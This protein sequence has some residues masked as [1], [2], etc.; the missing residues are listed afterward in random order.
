MKIDKVFAYEQLDSRG[1]PTIGIIMYSKNIFAKTLIPSG[2][3]TGSKEAFELRDNE[4]SYFGKGVNKAINN[5]NNI[6]SNKIIGLSIFEQRK[7]DNLMIELDGT[8]NKSNLGANAILAVSTCLTKL[9]AKALEIPL[10]EYISI[11]LFKNKEVVKHIPTPMINIINGG[12]HSNN[13]LT[14]QEFMIVPSKNSFSNQLK[15]CC[16]IFHLLGKKLEEKKYSISKGDEGGYSPNL[17]NNEEALD[18]ILESI[19][20]S[21]YKSGKDIFLAIDVAANEL[22]FKDKYKIFNN[23]DNDFLMG[24]ELIKYYLMLIKKYPINFIEDPF[25][26]ND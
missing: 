7:I 12:A 16:E 14:F 2:I 8:K 20:D 13:N 5:I 1:F 19:K 23:R 10:Y 3:S 6:I 4:D 21:N 24:P 17:S 11:N 18:L 25:A 22:Y 15:M 26:E 9:A